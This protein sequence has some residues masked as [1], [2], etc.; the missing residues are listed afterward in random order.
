[1]IN[2]GAGSGSQDDLML[3]DQ[4]ILIDDADRVI[5]AASKAAAHRFEGTTPTGLLHRA[6]SVFL[7][8]P[9]GAACGGPPP[10]T[11]EVGDQI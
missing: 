5:G 2:L 9:A 8:D 10:F 1:M 6:F 7:F 11:A 4:C 3:K